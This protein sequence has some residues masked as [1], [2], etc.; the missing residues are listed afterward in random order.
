MYVLH[1]SPTGVEQDTLAAAWSVGGAAA[2]RSSAWVHGVLDDPPDVPDVE[3]L[4]RRGR[5]LHPSKLT[6]YRTDQM[7]PDD[8]TRRR[9]IPVTSIERTLCDLG[10][11]VDTATLRG[12]ILRALQKGITHPD[13]LIRRH[14]ELGGKGRPGSA[15]ARKVLAEVDVDLMLLESD[16]ESALLAL[17]LEAGLPRPVLQHPI[18][19]DG[20]RY[21]IDMA[22]PELMI[23]IEADGFVVHNGRSAFED[24]RSRQNTLALAGWQVLRFTWRQVCTRRDWVVAQISEALDGAGPQR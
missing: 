19:L 16:L 11:V 23:A 7:P 2:R 5:D 17:I 14:L 21:R 4:F 9:G 24:D 15:A 13:R 22:Y 6:L 3:S 10:A 18:Q 1:G 20:R 8:V 12:C